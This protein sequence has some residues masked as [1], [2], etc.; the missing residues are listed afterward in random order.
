MGV[1][2]VLTRHASTHMGLVTFCVTGVNNEKLRV[3]LVRALE[4][5]GARRADAEICTHLITPSL[6]RTENTLR[7]MCTCLYV[8]T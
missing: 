8:H 5:L 6:G 3:D 2:P 7:A 1:V 4:K